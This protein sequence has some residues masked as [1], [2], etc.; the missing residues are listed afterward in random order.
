MTSF[1]VFCEKVEEFEL[2]NEIFHF[3]LLWLVKIVIYLCQ[4]AAPHFRQD[5]PTT[6]TRSRC[7]AIVNCIRCIETFR[8][9]GV[10]T[11]IPRQL[12][13]IIIQKVRNNWN[14]F[15]IH[16]FFFQKCV[17]LSMWNYV[18]PSLLFS[19]VFK[20]KIVQILQNLL[21]FFS[22]THGVST[23]LVIC[24]TSLCAQNYNHPNC[25]NYDFF[26]IYARRIHHI[27]QKINIW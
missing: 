16:I 3:L 27:S 9:S 10:A 1:E 23:P 2:Y 22:F 15:T 6:R 21:I 13:N 5:I 14:W 19:F 11:S 12:N 26:A 18:V 7:S 8:L 17:M 24:F 25:H 4:I 20:S